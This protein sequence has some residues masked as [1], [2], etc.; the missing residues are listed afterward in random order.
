MT[1][2]FITSL[3]FETM[4][5]IVF[6]LCFLILVKGNENPNFIIGGN[7]VPYGSYPFFVFL[8]A[9]GWPKSIT[10]GGSLISNYYILTAAHC[11]PNL[12]YSVTVIGILF[13]LKVSFLAIFV[14]PY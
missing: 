5:S 10:C 11:V 14:L 13:I 6:F 4:K 7:E 9:V 3:A 1:G 8:Q 12:S 2:C